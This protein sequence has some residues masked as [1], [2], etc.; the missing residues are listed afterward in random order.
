MKT[1]HRS[2]FLR[3]LLLALLFSF[4]LG[5]LSFYRLSPQFTPVEELNAV[6]AGCP[7]SQTKDQ[8]L[9]Y[10]YHREK[11]SASPEK[12]KSL[13]PMVMPAMIRL[14]LFDEYDQARKNIT[15]EFRK[16]IQYLQ[17]SLICIEELL[18]QS[19]L[20]RSREIYRE[21]QTAWDGQAVAELLLKR[22]AVS[23]E[24]L[25][26]LSKTNEI[27]S[28]LDAKFELG[29]LQIDDPLMDA[30]EQ[31]LDNPPTLSEEEKKQFTSVFYPQSQQTAL[32]LSKIV[33]SVDGALNRFGSHFIQLANRDRDYNTSV[34]GLCSSLMKLQSNPAR[35]DEWQRWLA[36]IDD[37]S[38]PGLLCVRDYSRGFLLATHDHDFAAAA[39]ILEKGVI[40]REICQ[41][42]IRDNTLNLLQRIKDDPHSFLELGQAPEDAPE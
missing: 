21:L 1:S 37:A 20:A 42:I 8:I 32:F 6:W 15:D 26:M 40:E 31:Q 34:I 16:S 33:G 30:L 4:A 17:N 7:Y 36:L 35:W 18:K 5:A 14:G 38:Y 24:T 11:N 2:A 19:D 22:A 29:E 25:T 3:S 23:I 12:M 9:V 13:L 39:N 41:G 27:I 28:R 10:I